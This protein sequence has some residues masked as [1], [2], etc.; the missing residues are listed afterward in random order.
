[1]KQAEQNS[2]CAIC[3]DMG[4]TNTRVWL[5]RD[6]EVLA[7]R[8]AG[9]GVRDTAREG[10]AN[11]IRAA[12]REMIADLRHEHDAAPA[13]VVAAGM[14][15]SPLGLAEV[16]HLPAPVGAVELAAAVRRFSFPE[17]CDLP[18]LFV[19]GVRSGAFAND[20]ATISQ[21]DVMRGEETLCIGLSTQKLVCP[22][23][24]VL[25]L[26]SHWKAIQLDATGRI[27]ASVTSLSGELVHATQTTTILASAV[28]AEKPT[29][30][31][32][33][34]CEAGRQEQQ[35]SGLA[36]AL[37]CVRMFELGQQGTPAQRMSFLLGVYIAADLH[38]MLAHDVITCDQPVTI[39]GSGAVALGWQ[40][41][42]AQVSIPTVILSAEEVEHGLLAGLQTI[43]AAVSGH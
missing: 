8:Q 40:H 38:A 18:F 26:G 42:L 22:P 25:N 35:R 30:L 41:A 37:F 7:R 4:T 16:P 2:F 29:T 32:V 34:W 19:P 21:A 6:G 28:P 20:F 3:V 13:C 17:I 31:D 27:A 39:T 10:S 5:V 24:T 1:M 11:R 9:A 14:I 43:L 23:A 33:T 36:R 15:A 12:L